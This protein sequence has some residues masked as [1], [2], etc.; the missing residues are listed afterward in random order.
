MPDAEPGA[1]FGGAISRVFLAETAEVEFRAGRPKARLPRDKVTLSRP[2]RG[3]SASIVRWSG[4]RKP[5]K[6]QAARNNPDVM[7]KAPPLS[8]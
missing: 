1:Q 6:S 5:E 8:A 4:N 3:N 2:M 7:S